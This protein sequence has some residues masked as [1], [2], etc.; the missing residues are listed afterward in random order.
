MKQVLIKK[1]NAVVGETPVPPVSSG[2]V[3]VKVAYSL[4][5]TGTEMA[6]I[7]RSGASLFQRVIA[8]PNN[9]KKVIGLAEKQGIGRTAEAV[10]RQTTSET[11]TGYSCSGKIVKTGKGISDLYVGDLVACAG[12]GKAYHAEYVSVPRNLTAK[13]PEKCSVEDAASVTLGAIA[14]QGVRR[15]G[16]SLGETVAVIGLG[17]IGQITCQLLRAAGCAVAGIDIDD[18][19]IHLAQ[20]L[21]MKF[22]VN[23][24][25]EDPIAFVRNITAEAS[26]RMPSLSPRT[27]RKTP[28]SSRRWRLRERRERS[29]LW[30]PS[31]WGSKESPF[32]K[33]NL[34]C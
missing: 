20:T 33:R 22:G 2:N 3:L 25:M 23:P 13:I 27:Q 14:M 17:L 5:S 4:V 19:R 18:S 1:G 29:S 28:L 12:A 30:D 31:V 6:G 7:Q 16:V 32:M 8:N 9:I 24:L 15:S 10:K 21:G 34:T 11:A 26:G